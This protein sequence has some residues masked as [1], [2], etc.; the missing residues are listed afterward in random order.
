MYSLYLAAF[1]GLWL[2]FICLSK[3]DKKGEG[4]MSFIYNKCLNNYTEPEYSDLI[5]AS[6]T[7]LLDSGDR[8]EFETGA[9][10]VML[11]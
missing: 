7:I 1:L 8:R 6:R 11:S 4:N 3:E 10:R 9:V 2:H 5:T